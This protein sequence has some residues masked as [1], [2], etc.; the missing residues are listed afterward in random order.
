MTVLY[1]DIKKEL[2]SLSGALE[3]PDAS[4]VEFRDLPNQS[5]PKSRSAHG[6]ASGLVHPDK[7]VEDLRPALS[8]DTDAGV[9][10]L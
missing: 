4:T 5:Q 7:R 2:C 6:P 9:R 10:D 3:H 1:R 8:G